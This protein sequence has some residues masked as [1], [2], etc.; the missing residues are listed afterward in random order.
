MF[1]FSDKNSLV[2]HFVAELRDENIQRDSWRFRRNLERLG[3][4]MAYEISKGLDYQAAR[5]K[6]P[7]GVANTYLLS[8]QPILATILRAGLPFYQGFLNFFDQAESAF[9]GAYRGPMQ[10]DNSFEIVQSYTAA[11][12]LDQKVLILID[13]M[14]AT[15][16]SLVSVYEALLRY[17]LPRQVHVVAAIASRAGTEHLQAHI[18][19][20]RL[21][22]GSLDET[23]NHKSYIVPGLGDAGDLAFGN[24]Q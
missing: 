10:D 9:V 12:S 19:E 8:Q 23:L 13:P 6:T 22:L 18:P 17:G 11:P 14:L 3:E 20:A 2:N 16:R 15:G 24:K 5:I 1:V 7:L 21:W 4:V